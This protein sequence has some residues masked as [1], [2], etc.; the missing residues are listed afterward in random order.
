MI[1]KGKQ[2]GKQNQKG[3]Y[4]VYIWFVVLLLQCTKLWSISHTSCSIHLPGLLAVGLHQ[5]LVQLV[6]PGDI[7]LAEIILLNVSK[8]SHALIPVLMFL[9]ALLRW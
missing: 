1:K 2:P 9:H 8:N 5:A 4:E 6:H 7:V 3:D